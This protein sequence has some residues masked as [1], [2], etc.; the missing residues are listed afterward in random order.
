MKD[1]VGTVRL[2]TEHKKA[3]PLGGYEGASRAP[4]AAVGRSHFPHHPHETSDFTLKKSPTHPGLGE[5]LV[6]PPPPFG[7]SGGSKA[8]RAREQ[9]RALSA[10]GGRGT[11]PC[12][13]ART[14]SARGPR[15]PSPR[16]PGAVPWA[17]TGTPGARRS[18]EPS[19][20]PQ[21]CRGKTTSSPALPP[22]PHISST[23]VSL[24]A[25]EQLAGIGLTFSLF[26]KT[27]SVWDRKT[28]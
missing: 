16:S 19:L 17:G 11:E 15:A 9:G 13:T 3:V 7:G 28:Q 20:A 5:L 23:T 4:G 14:A 26:T 22:P 12:F 1:L 8:A 2:G 21:T 27:L 24:W 18:T 25:V 6:G 10:A